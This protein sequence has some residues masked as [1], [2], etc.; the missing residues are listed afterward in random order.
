VRLRVLERDGSAVLEVEDLGRGI[1]L[2]ERER[3]FE[4]FVRLG[5]TRA[6]GS[7]LGLAI[8]KELAELMDGRIVLESEPGRTVFALVLPLGRPAERVS[9]ENAPALS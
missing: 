8:A 6:S 7:G 5:G 3:L 1:P 9:R 4:R 2:E